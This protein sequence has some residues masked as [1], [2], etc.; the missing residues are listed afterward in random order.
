VEFDV[1]ELGGSRVTVHIRLDATEVQGAFDRTYQQLSSRGGIKGFRPGKV[2]RSILERHYDRDAIRAATYEAVIQ[3][4]LQETM[5]QENLRP[6]DQIGIEVG[7]PPDEDEMLAETI[8]A[9]L[10]REEDAEDEVEEPELADD[11]AGEGAE[12]GDPDHEHEFEDDLPEIPLVEGEPFEFYTVFTAYPRPTLPDLSDLKLRRPVA[13]VTEEQVGDHLERLRRIN[14]EEVEVDRDTIEEGDLVVADVK[15]V[16]EGED[17]DELEPSQQEIVVGEREYLGEIDRALI[18]HV[19][20]DIVEAEFDYGDDHPDEDLRGRAGRIIAEIDSFS[21]RELPELDDEFARGL[22]AY[23]SLDDLR[24]SIRSALVAAEEEHAHEEL[25]AQVMRY[26]LEGTEV[27]LPEEFVERAAAGTHE[28]LMRELRQ[29][30]MS[31]A[32]FAEAADTAEED[33][34][35]GQRTRAESGLKLHFAL[36]TLAEQLEIEVAEEDI[37]AEI[38]RIADESGGDVGFAQQAAMLQ[39][40]FAEEIQ[41]RALRRKLIEQVIA[42]AEVEDV[43]AE[44][45]HA[46]QAAEEDAAEDN[47][48][49]E[50]EASDI[51]DEAADSDQ[52]SEA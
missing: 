7:A 47:G 4:R 27:E 25:R 30:G 1:R 11:E 5:E 2:P 42:S 46:E 49:R 14:A 48:A 40:D 37:A 20:G 51:V 28:Q 31:L 44:Q 35:A 34:R 41:D 19:P 17:A 3:D 9:G 21:G 22:G 50:T 33:L 43:P 45:Y 36:E 10:V 32:E 26:V 18:G 38:A 6:I 12:D 52:E 23:E 29:T 39:P 24:E 13:E 15:V 8:R 16:A